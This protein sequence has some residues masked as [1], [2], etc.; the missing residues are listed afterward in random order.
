MNVTALAVPGLPW[1]CFSV[2]V[3]SISFVLAVVHIAGVE[4]VDMNEHYFIGVL[5]LFLVKDRL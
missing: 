4:L 1:T 5:N 2:L 3:Y